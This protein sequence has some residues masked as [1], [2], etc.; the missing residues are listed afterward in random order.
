V[1]GGG[2]GLACAP[3][4]PQIEQHLCGLLVHPPR[5]KVSGLGEEATLTGA[6]TH[7]AS[8]VADSFTA[9]RIAGAAA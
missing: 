5:V 2:I 9:R 4:I 1:L 3:Q 7:G 8:L 6:L